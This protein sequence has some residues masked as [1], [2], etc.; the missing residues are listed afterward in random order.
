MQYLKSK[1]IRY[2][3]CGRHPSKEMTMWIYIRCDELNNAL[4]EYESSEN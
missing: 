2:E 1:N 3:L 4:N